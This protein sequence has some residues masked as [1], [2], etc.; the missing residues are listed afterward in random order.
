[1]DSIGTYPLPLAQ[2]DRFL[3]KIRMQHIDRAA[4]LEVLASWGKPR[5][6]CLLPKVTRSDVVKA[7]DLLRGQVYVAPQV[8]S[9][10]VDLARA[11]RA[12][13]RCTQGVST[14]S[15]VQAVPA[16]QTLALLRGRDFVSADDVDYLA[17]P[18]LQHRVALVPGVAEP[19]EVIRAALPGPLEELARVSR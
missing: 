19:A 14:R 2:L 12:D 8:M 5:S 7:R 16:L 9:C 3:F 15:L 10:L 4:E 1:L 6:G 13:R 17:V 18:L 11:I